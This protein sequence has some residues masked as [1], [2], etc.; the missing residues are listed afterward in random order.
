LKPVLDCPPYFVHKKSYN[1]KFVIWGVAESASQRPLTGRNGQV[2]T[3][4]RTKWM[5]GR[6]DDGMD[7]G[8]DG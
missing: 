7:D 4:G 1:S 6:M 8:M 3:D 2:Q 5:E